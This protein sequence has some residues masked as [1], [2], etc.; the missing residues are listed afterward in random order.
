MEFAQLV[1][2]CGGTYRRII[3]HTLS[4]NFR[5]S[6]S[7][8]EERFPKELGNTE[9]VIQNHYLGINASDINFTNGRYAPDVKPPF[10]CGF[11]AIGKVKAVGQDVKKLKAGDAV[12]MTLFGAFSEYLIMPEKSVIKIPFVSANILPMVVCGSTASIALDKVGNMAHGET[13]MVT[14]AAGATGQ[15]AVQLAKLAGNHVIGT[16]SNE[17][18]VDYLKSLGCDR[19]INYKEESVFQVLKN[20]Y[21]KGVDLVFEAVG[22]E[23]FD[24]CVNNLAVKGRLIVIGAISGYENASFWE[25]NKSNRP[26]PK[27]SV[28]LATK[29]LQKSA[30]VRG[31]FLN[32][33]TSDAAVHAKKL[34]NLVQ[35]GK[36]NP[37]VDPT[38]FV[39]L[40]AVADALDYMYARKNIGKLVVSLPVADAESVSRL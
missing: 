7:I 32:H 33:F 2:Q 10:P 12:S 26:E 14:A 15:F 16:C 9:V 8:V 37:G 40:E 13:V 20:E 23:M 30:S 17:A 39:G 6:T 18:K 22:G 34:S 3:C 21:P 35:A 4:S 19:V 11:E 28:P 25:Q 31:F 24:A 27:T 5:Q 29:L 38:P 36:L 1:Q